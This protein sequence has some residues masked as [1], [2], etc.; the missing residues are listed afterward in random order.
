MINF[1][2]FRKTINEA[3]ANKSAEV[4]TF[5]IKK[6]VAVI[7]QEGNRFVAYLDKDRLDSFKSE[8]DAVQGIK[9]FVSLLDNK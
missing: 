5:K 1:K 2:S 7:K 4:K 6:F 9:D 3:V 8:K